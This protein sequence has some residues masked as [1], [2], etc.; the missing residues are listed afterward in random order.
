M[1]ALLNKFYALSGTQIVNP[2]R[3]YAWM[4]AAVALNVFLYCPRAH[5][6]FIEEA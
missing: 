1:T 2:T 4:I 5:V 6:D 3:Y